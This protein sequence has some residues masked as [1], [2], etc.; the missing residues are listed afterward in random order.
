MSYQLPIINFH[1]NRKKFVS[2]LIGSILFIVSTNALSQELRVKSPDSTILFKVSGVCSLCKQ[3]IESA[4]K[5]QGVKAAFW[6]FDRK[7]L[8]ITYDPQKSTLQKIS[9]RI[10]D[11]GYDTQHQK[12][13]D[14]DY[15]LLPECCQYREFG[16]TPEL[17]KKVK[18]KQV[19]TDL[20]I[21][22][23]DSSNKQIENLATALQIV[24]G[25]VLVKNQYD[26]LT[27]LAGANVTLM[28]SSKGT[29]TD[30]NG[31]FKLS[32][33]E[34][35][36]RFVVSFAGYRSDTVNI[37]GIDE[38]EVILE[39]GRQLQEI[40]ITI[41]GGHSPTYINS[42]DPLR[43][44]IISQNELK[45]AAC[46]NLSESFETN[47]SVDVSA[48]DAVTGSKQIQLLGLSGNYTQLTVENLPGP[49]GL[50]TPLGLNSIPGTWIESIQLVKG[51]GSVA[52]GFE[53]MAGQINLELKKPGASER[54]YANVYVNDFGKTD[55]NFNLTQRVGKKWS[56]TLLLH[57]AFLKNNKIDFNGD[58]FRDLPTGNLFSAVNRWSF[59]NGK[60]L[61]THFGVKLLDD[62]KVG[63]QVNFNPSED[64]LTTNSYGLQI[65]TRRKE[66]FGKLGYVFPK[67]TY[68]SIGL[69]MS[70]FNHQQ[71]S[72]FGLT[73]YNASQRNFYSTLI[74]QS[75]IGSNKHKFRTGVSFVYDGYDEQF[76]TA[77]Y[78]RK[79]AV[80]GGFF[81]YTFSPSSIFD[82]VAGVR[83][84][85]NS[86][87]G[88]FTTPKLS[89]RYQPLK[90]TIIR[91][92]VGRG[93]RT[94]NIFAENNSVFVS[95]RNI[96]IRS[97]SSGGAYGLNPEIAWNK[98][99][100]VDQK[101]RLFNRGANFSVEFFRNDFQNQI[102]V[103]L[104][105]P[106]NVSFYDLQGKSY[107]NS[108][109]AEV[110]F[111]PL[112]KFNVRLAYR[113]FDVM[114]SYGDNLLQRPFTA[115]DRG[116]ANLAYEVKNW[117]IDYTVSYNGKKRI[118]ST[119][120]FP[121]IYRREAH[122]PAFALM[123]SQ[124]SNT[125]GKNKN[126]DLYIGGENL[127][128]F[129]Q[130]DV[131]TAA[132]QPFSSYFDASLIWGPVNGRMLYFG[133]RIFLK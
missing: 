107:A 129:F 20:A 66:A 5:G 71:D 86:L 131:I 93:Q 33:L 25:V 105:D 122:S 114:G 75:H 127:T 70:T 130:R 23:C 85:Y 62:E 116:F 108:F 12:T 99:I 126:I 52:N 125:L 133:F 29:V 63:G 117:R 48:N 41:K 16:S 69:Q 81:E 113:Y 14:K 53:S 123:N 68:Q 88:W 112:R 36:T 11:A 54:L 101:F 1:K 34:G 24:K 60:G 89:L 2:T 76:N 79:E 35:E 119:E 13:D 120:G 73:T 115:R 110:S 74:Y 132:D 61:T 43:T 55:L 72:Y 80:S 9:K 6:D 3:R 111:E 118:P 83:E 28:E 49:R 128:N 17:D 90:R 39:V 103:D 92:S 106:T 37:I 109:Q 84:D 44:M 78:K 40:K 64:K 19:H 32:I 8:S 57:D 95:A 51:T 58:G 10:N 121:A 4:A 50:A 65:N 124:I 21:P 98:G 91:A 94:A 31:T 18:R 56:T 97:T 22:T 87:Y 46:C 47:P 67:K 38:V 59:D 27:P 45:K 42:Y 15:K 7:I 82:V 30:K 77:D 26:S 104:E 96:N 102:I 100:T